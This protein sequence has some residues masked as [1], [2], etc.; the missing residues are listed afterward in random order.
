MHEYLE[1][2]EWKLALH[3][4]L[5]Y[6]PNLNPDEHVWSHIKRTGVP[7]RPLRQ[8]EK[9]QEKAI[10]QLTEIQDQRDHV[11]KLFNTPMSPIF[12]TAD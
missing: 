6:A 9:F 3:F 11:H 12:T 2:T 1:S 8:S 5:G 7:R 4:L 10:E